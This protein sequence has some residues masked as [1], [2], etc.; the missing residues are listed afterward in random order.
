MGI[1]A[2]TL[3]VL[4]FLPPKET[5]QDSKKNTEITQTKLPV[6]TSTVKNKEMQENNLEEIKSSQES[7]NLL[8]TAKSMEEENFPSDNQD[9]I[10]LSCTEDNEF[11]LDTISQVEK[12]LIIEYQQILIAVT[13]KSLEEFKNH[14]S[15]LK[16]QPNK[17]IQAIYQNDTGWVYASKVEIIPN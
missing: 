12:P 2:V 1:V 13:T 8:Q 7:S 17:L 5:K 3:I 15:N 10:W 14:L 4:M 11:F 16:K 9:N 6:T